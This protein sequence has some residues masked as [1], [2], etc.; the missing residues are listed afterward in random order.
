MGSGGLG[1]PFK[2]SDE[3]DDLCLGSSAEGIPL[4]RRG[5][6]GEWV[7]G[8]VSGDGEWEVNSVGLNNVSFNE[9]KR[10]Y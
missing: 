4:L 7:W 9:R 5:S 6:S 3:D 2:E 8:S 1:P 10:I